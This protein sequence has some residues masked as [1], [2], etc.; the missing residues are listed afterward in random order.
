LLAA[1]GCCGF[2]EEA[3]DDGLFGLDLAVA[4]EAEWS[5]GYL[6]SETDVFGL[7]FSTV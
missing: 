2:G 6:W 7:L 3:H 4:G 5:V 1:A